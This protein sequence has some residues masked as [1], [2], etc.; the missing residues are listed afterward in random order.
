M[1][2]QGK[3]FYYLAQSQIAVTFKGIKYLQIGLAIWQKI[4][5]SYPGLGKEEDLFIFNFFISDIFYVEITYKRIMLFT[6]HG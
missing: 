3:L 5:A 1:S 2:I 4:Q 6:R